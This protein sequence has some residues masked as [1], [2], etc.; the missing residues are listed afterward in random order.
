MKVKKFT[1]IELLVVIAIIG[2]LAAML[3]PALQQARERARQTTCLNNHGTFG[4][5]IALYADDNKGFF[6]PYWNRKEGWRAND[7]YLKSYWSSSY[8][9]GMLAPYFGSSVTGNSDVPLAGAYFMTSKKKWIKCPL[10]CPSTTPEALKH[11]KVRDSERYPSIGRNAYS[12]TVKRISR[13]ARPNRT[14][15]FMDTLGS[16]DAGYQHLSNSTYQIDF[17]HSNGLNVVFIDSHAVYYRYGN[18]PVSTT[19]Y[20]YWKQSFWMG[21][22]YELDTW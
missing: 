14:S 18:I 1:L 21:S 11:Y 2:I 17:R 9:K 8:T 13:Y 6:V 3:L 19:H 4:K 20:R 16:L 7:P 12:G 10:F 22:G 15:A 5:V